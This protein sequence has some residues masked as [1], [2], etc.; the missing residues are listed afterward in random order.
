MKTIKD[1]DRLVCTAVRNDPVGFIDIL[2]AESNKAPHEY[3]PLLR[4][5]ACL[6]ANLMD[7]LGIPER[8]TITND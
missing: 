3:A 6:I 7:K 1:Y 8:G 4:E 5:A 2:I